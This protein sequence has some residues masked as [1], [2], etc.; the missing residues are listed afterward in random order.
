MAKSYIDYNIYGIA[1]STNFRTTLP[2]LGTV[3]MA[4]IAK[5]L[6]KYITMDTSDLK[7]RDLKDYFAATNEKKLNDIGFYPI[8][9]MSIS[10]E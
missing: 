8:Q 2:I 9:T 3:D 5:N 4:K 10:I 7:E 1:E 6:A